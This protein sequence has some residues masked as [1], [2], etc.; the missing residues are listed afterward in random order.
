MKN[1]LNKLILLLVA[2]LVF[3]AC[4]NDDDGIVAVLNPNASVDVTLSTSSVVLDPNMADAEALFVSWMQ[5]D[6]GYN[7]AADYTILFDNAGGDFSDAQSVSAGIGLEKSL[8]TSKLNG[9]LLNLGFEQDVPGDIEIRVVAGLGDYNS[10][11][12]ESSILNATAYEDLL[13]QSTTWGVVGSAAN[14]WGATPDLPFYTTGTD[15]VLVAYVTLIDGQIKF[16]KDNAWDLNYGDTGADGTLEEGGDN[17][18]V[19]AGT[20]EIIMNLNNLTYTMAPLSWGIVGSAYNN[21]GA[22][23][24]AMLTYDPYSDQWR[25]IVTLLDGDMKFR[26]NNDWGTN[27][28]DTGVDGVLDL[29]G[30]NIVVTAGIYIVTVNFNDLTY[31]MEEI[32]YVWGLVGGAYNNWGATPDAQFTR[33]WSMSDEVWILND[34]TLI[35]GEWKI[36]AN[37]D[38]GVN[39][40]SDDG[41]TLVDGGANI[42]ATA[43]TYTVRL[44]FSDPDN[45]TY[46]IE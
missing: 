36:R 45:P 37:N 35:D 24:D 19:T 41:V 20:Y 40:G 16:R 12:S 29:N 23:P 7:A 15:G 17:I 32:Q 25:T 22:T 38:W 30:D 46:T 6:F 4:N 31:T 8:T 1:I 5:P 18:D 13:D 39:Y 9:I 44:D 2:P 27:Y 42:L 33:D 26:L 11:V 3:V 43:G 28:G 34:V 10:I 21:W 14:D